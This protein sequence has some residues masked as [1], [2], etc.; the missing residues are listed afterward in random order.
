MRLAHVKYSLTLYFIQGH[1]H[2]FLDRAREDNGD[3]ANLGT[4]HGSNT[5]AAIAATVTEVVAQQRRTAP[6]P[7]PPHVIFPVRCAVPPVSWP[8]QRHDW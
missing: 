8:L 7:L 2:R 1:S 3:R 4:A 5:H 6:A